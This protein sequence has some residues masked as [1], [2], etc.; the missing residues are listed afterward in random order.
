MA[1]RTPKILIALISVSIVL[2]II[3]TTCGGI[4]PLMTKNMTQLF[5]SYRMVND[6][7]FVS[8]TVNPETD[9]PTVLMDYAKKFDANMDQWHFLTGSREAITDIAVHGFKLGSIEE[10]IF[11]SAKFVLVDRQL[12]IRGYYDGTENAEL[13]KLFKDVATL[14]NERH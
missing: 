9:T 14:L 6:V 7:S 11:H 3:F 5:R 13:S 2:S 1:Q 12:H 10:P 8:I 4:C